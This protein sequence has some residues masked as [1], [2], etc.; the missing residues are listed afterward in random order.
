MIK[1]LFKSFFAPASEI[2]DDGVLI[3][4]Q[5]PEYEKFQRGKWWY[6]AAFVLVGALISYSLITLNFLFAVIIL[7][8]LF[9]AVMRHFQEPNKITIKVAIEGIEVGSN[10]YPYKELKSF[11]FVYQ[12]PVVKK[13]YVD[14]HN[15]SRPLMIP[16]QDINP[17]KVREIL[18]DYLLENLEADGESLTQMVSRMAKF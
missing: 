10:F 12:P 1:D 4:W 9:I 2:N 13:L 11:W 3:A 18:N 15:S 5:F 14:M 6:V 17:L 16:L 8:V 7:L